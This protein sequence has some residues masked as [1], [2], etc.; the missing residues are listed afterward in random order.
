MRN[1]RWLAAGLLGLLIIA[2]TVALLWPRPI[3]PWREQGFTPG[4][5]ERLNARS[6]W[7]QACKS[8]NGMS[9]ECSMVNPIVEQVQLIVE[10][11]HVT[12]VRASPLWNWFSLFIDGPG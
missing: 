1:L 7:K 12:E 3:D 11:V 10:M 5:R 4:Q 6:W 9:S 2:A 8:Q